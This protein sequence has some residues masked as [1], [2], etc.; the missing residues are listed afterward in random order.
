MAQWRDGGSKCCKYRG[1]SEVC[2]QGMNGCVLNM[3]KE[4][5]YFREYGDGDVWR[6]NECFGRVESIGCAAVPGVQ[7]IETRG[8]SFYEAPPTQSNNT[9]TDLP[10]INRAPTP[11]SPSGRS[12]TPELVRGGKVEGAVVVVVVVV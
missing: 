6:V 12:A 2:V 11:L 8:R 7:S 9:T 5:Q 3:W 1:R 4:V 10:D